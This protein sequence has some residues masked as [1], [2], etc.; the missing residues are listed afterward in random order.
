[1]KTVH[2]RRRADKKSAEQSSM[3]RKEFTAFVD[4]DRVVDEQM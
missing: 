4:P 3:I 2:Q 1:M